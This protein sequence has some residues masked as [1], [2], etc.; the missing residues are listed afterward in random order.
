MPVTPPDSCFISRTHS[1][2]P[3]ALILTKELWLESRNPWRRAL[4]WTAPPGGVFSLLLRM[5]SSH[6]PAGAEFNH[7]WCGLTAPE[8]NPNRSGR[9]S[10]PLVLTLP[11]FAFPPRETASHFLFP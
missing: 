1:L 9:N 7:A 6:T 5:E 2:K 8:D 4:Q 3:R 11:D 10:T